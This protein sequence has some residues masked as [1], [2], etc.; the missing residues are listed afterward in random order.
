MYIYIDES[1]VFNIPTYRKWSVS[2]VGALV[3]PES[4]RDEI[5]KGIK[6]WRRVWGYFEGEMKGRSLNENEIASLIEFLS[7]FDLIFEITAIDM[8]MQSHQGIVR[9]RFSQADAFTENLTDQY[10]P[11]FMKQVEGIQKK[12]RVLANPLYVQAICTFK[13]LYSVFQKATLYYAQRQPHELSYFHWIMDAKGRDLTPFEDLW[14]TIVLPILQSESIKNPFI[15]LKGAN[16]SHLDKYFHTKE[17]T[18]DYL[19]NAVGDKRPF[20]Y[21][22][23]NEIFKRN[24]RFEQ[25][26]RNIGL[27][28]VDVLTTSVRRAM[29]GN[30]KIEG[31]GNIG[32]LMVTSEKS[33]NTIRLIDLCDR[34]RPKY[35]KT[36]PP[37]WDVVRTVDRSCKPLLLK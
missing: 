11:N 2:C 27:Q 15:T 37:Y 24:L 8:V 28:L 26:H 10:H 33:S 3:I 12:L 9:H 21:V 17:Q 4:D 18:P 22:Q 7:G 25:S 29:N 30:L 31:W 5:F 36:F 1:G 13:L 20:H 16:Y 14:T 34:P 6:K 35:G 32:R 23:I 19:R